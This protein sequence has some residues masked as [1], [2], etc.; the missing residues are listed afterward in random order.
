MYGKLDVEKWY[1]MLDPDKPNVVYI[2]RLCNDD[3]YIGST[4]D[5][6]RRM[7]EH[8]D[9]LDLGSRMTRKNPVKEIVFIENYKTYLLANRRE[10][11]I[12]KWSR[13]KK[14]ALIA[15]RLLEVSL[16]AHGIKPESVVIK[17]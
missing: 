11:Q 3:L 16:L 8:E 9:C 2:L 1:P 7:Q 14:E 5:F 6:R 17:T 12:K 10:M 15:D 4:S 13:A